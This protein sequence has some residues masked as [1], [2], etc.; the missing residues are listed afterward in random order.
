MSSEKV[1]DQESDVADQ[2]RIHTPDPFRHHEQRLDVGQIAGAVKR[3]P[4]I[5]FRSAVFEACHFL[6][7][8]RPDADVV[9]ELVDAGVT[10]RP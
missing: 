2:V 1:V 7:V 8:I 5:Q 6:Q 4:G 10:V 3:Q 9:E